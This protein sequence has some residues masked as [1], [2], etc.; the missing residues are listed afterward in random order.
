MSILTLSPI[1]PIRKKRQMACSSI[2]NRARKDLK[3]SLGKTDPDGSSC[4]ICIYY[5]FPKNRV[6]RIAF[7]CIINARLKMFI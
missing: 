6:M 4:Q 1:N 2:T 5:R 7:L 3:K